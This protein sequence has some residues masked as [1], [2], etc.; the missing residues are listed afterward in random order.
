MEVTGSGTTLLYA[1]YHACGEGVMECRGRCTPR[2][3]TSATTLQQGRQG[4]DLADAQ[5]GFSTPGTAT[6]ARKA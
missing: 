1:R 4:G 3:S 5:P 2:S 6:A